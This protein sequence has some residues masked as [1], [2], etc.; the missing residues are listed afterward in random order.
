MQA[1]FIP[2]LILEGTQKSWAD[3]PFLCGMSWME[4]CALQHMS[5]GSPS[6]PTF[7]CVLN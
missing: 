6:R 2:L 4:A 7:M 5:M 3:F 1:E